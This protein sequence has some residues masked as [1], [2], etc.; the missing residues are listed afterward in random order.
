MPRGHANNGR[1][2]G[3]LMWN[4]AYIM[5]AYIGRLIMRIHKG[6]AEANDSCANSDDHI[7]QLLSVGHKLRRKLCYP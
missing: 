5:R 2:H 1:L 4:K 6:S 7:A 3:E